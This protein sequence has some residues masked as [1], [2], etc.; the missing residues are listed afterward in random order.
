M[1]EFLGASSGLG[2]GNWAYPDFSLLED[3]RNH[4]SRDE[5]SGGQRDPE[6]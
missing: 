6:V 1:G 2:S 3:R 4:T 5:G